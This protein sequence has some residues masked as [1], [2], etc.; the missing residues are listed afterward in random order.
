MNLSIHFTGRP[1]GIVPKIKN[2]TISIVFLIYQFHLG[3]IKQLYN[4]AT[5]KCEKLTI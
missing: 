1:E 4:F 2:W 3:I 5:N